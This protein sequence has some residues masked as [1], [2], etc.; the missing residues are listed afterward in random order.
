MNGTRGSTSKVAHSHGWQTCQLVLALDKTFRFSQAGI[1]TL[2]SECYLRHFHG[3]SDPRWQSRCYSDLWP[4]L[5]SHACHSHHTPLA[6]Q[7][8]PHGLS[9]G[10]SHST[11]HSEEPRTWFKVLMLPYWF[12]WSFNLWT[13][14]SEV[15]RNQGVHMWAEK[16]VAIC[17]FTAIPHHSF[18]CS[19][20]NA[21]N[22]GGKSMR[23]KARKISACIE[24]LQFSEY[25]G[26]GHVFFF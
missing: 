9:S 15:N 3:A 17:V 20:S 6:T 21:Q 8:Q 4:S 16:I 25:W 7:R 11:L 26:N 12:S 10:Q 13:F 23:P 14:I 18:A 5:G 22:S 1:S 24:S 19:I 2:L